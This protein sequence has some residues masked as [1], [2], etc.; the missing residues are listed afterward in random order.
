MQRYITVMAISLWGV[1][2]VDS[3]QIATSELVYDFN[4]LYSSTVNAG[5]YNILRFRRRSFVLSVFNLFP[6]TWRWVP[7]EFRGPPDSDSNEEQQSRTP[8]RPSP[9]SPP[10]W[11]DYEHSSDSIPSDPILQREREDDCWGL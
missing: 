3:F 1:I 11:D 5:F 2:R 7:P 6:P 9:T 8:T 10:Y 4:I